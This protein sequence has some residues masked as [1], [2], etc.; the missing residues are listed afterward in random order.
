M[1]SHA[2]PED[3]KNRR[4]I[5]RFF[6]K[7][8][9]GG[10]ITEPNPKIHGFGYR[11]MC[12]FF[13]SLIFH[14]PLMQSFDYFMRLDGGDSRIGNV[15]VDVFSLMHA[16]KLDYTFRNPWRWKVNLMKELHE[17]WTKANPKVVWN[18]ALKSAFAKQ[19]RMFYNNFEVVRTVPFR[20]KK[21]WS[22]FRLFDEEG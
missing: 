14:S 1:L 5:Y 10:N 11:N 22:Y 6:R 17:R 16:Q 4:V 3:Y 7:W 15:S 20:T 8:H 13:S 19:R 12:R 18:S 2:N 21:H 9:P